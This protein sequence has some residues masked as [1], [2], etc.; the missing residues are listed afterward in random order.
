MLH[1]KDLRIGYKVEPEFA[2]GN[3]TTK[4]ECDPFSAGEVTSLTA[5]NF[6][7]GD[8][9]A[10]VIQYEKE[11][12][13]APGLGAL[14]VVVFNKG[15]NYKGFKLICFVQS[16]VWQVEAARGTGGELMAKS[17]TA[18]YSYAF[19]FEIPGLDGAMDYFDAMGCV[20]EEYE[21]DTNSGDW[22]KEILTFRCYDIIDSVAVT[23]MLDFLQIQPYI[24]KDAGLSIDG[25]TISDFSKLNLKITNKFMSDDS[26]AGK[27]QRFDPYL[28]EKTIV[29]D[30]TAFTDS[31]AVFGDPTI[32]ALNYQGCGLTG[33][34]AGTETGLG[35]TTQY[36][37]K[38]SVNG[39][40]AI[41][42]DITTAADTTFA[43]VIALM[44]TACV[45]ANGSFSLIGGDLVFT[46]NMVLAVI[47]LSAGQVTDLFGA[48]TNFTAFA[49][50][51]YGLYPVI[52]NNGADT[53]Q[54]TLLRV[55]DDN[56]GEIP[57]FGIFEHKIVC[58][59]G[60]K[61]VLSIT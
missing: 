13:K 27:Y 6:I 22:P 4:Y 53:L 50:A 17:A 52:V 57:T 28:V 31:A 19:H 12:I 10:P 26:P 34:E 35:V 23:N 8:S 44:N 24:H 48:L 25:D 39:A 29:I 5:M 58:S 54:A 3:G 2:A 59:N 33:K 1:T 55:E 46:H 32:E 15:Y 40:A 38:I 42:Y 51:V 37:F 16:A 56:M 45:A 14:E 21:Y 18:G 7:Q 20:L 36:Y 11:A 49:A 47:A 60:G 43:A 41:E 61:V 30:S 9:N